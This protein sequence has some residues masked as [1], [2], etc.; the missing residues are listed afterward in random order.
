M[1]FTEE[2][3][4][5]LQDITE[6]NKMEKTIENKQKEIENIKERFQV[7]VQESGDVFEIITSDWTIKYIS[8]TSEKGIKYKP[9]KLI[10]EKIYKFY[11]GEELEKLNKMVNFVLE[12]SSNKIQEIL[13]FKTRSGELYISK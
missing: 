4:E 9:E 5:R 11:E 12:D 7:L 3:L 13:S 1:A 2:D 8:E 10:G 6:N